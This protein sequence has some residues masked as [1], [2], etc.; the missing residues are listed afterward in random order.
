[1]NEAKGYIDDAANAKGRI[2]GTER[3]EEKD[4]SDEMDE[5]SNKLFYSQPELLMI[6]KI[7][8]SSED[9]DDIEMLLCNDIFHDDDDYRKSEDDDDFLS[10]NEKEDENAILRASSACSYEEAM[11][12][13]IALARVLHGGL[14]DELDRQWCASI[15]GD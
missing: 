14:R 11:A 10:R 2:E 13:L 4:P 9:E 3:P 12:K 8:E 6:E 7:D 1:M 15:D 5:S